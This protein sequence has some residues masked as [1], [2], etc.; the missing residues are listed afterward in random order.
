MT[1]GN[2][3]LVLAKGPQGQIIPQFPQGMMVV[4]DLLDAAELLENMAR[5]VNITLSAPEVEA[6]DGVLAEEEAG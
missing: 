3:I 4:G 2:I 1:E 6:V 5:N